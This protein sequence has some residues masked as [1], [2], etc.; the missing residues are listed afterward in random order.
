MEA[1]DIWINPGTVGRPAGEAAGPA[2]AVDPRP[3]LGDA[4]SGLVGKVLA[5]P[6]V[7]KI[8]RDLGINLADVVPTGAPR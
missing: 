4:I 6:P 2:D 7:R 3:T 8:A 1:H 5:K